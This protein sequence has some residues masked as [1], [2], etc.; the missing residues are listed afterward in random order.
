MHARLVLLLPFWN[1]SAGEGGLEAFHERSRQ[2]PKIALKRKAECALRADA[3][4]EFLASIFCLLV[5]N[6]LQMWYM[7]LLELI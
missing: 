6:G 3:C 5:L 7:E 4:V 2:P 1:C